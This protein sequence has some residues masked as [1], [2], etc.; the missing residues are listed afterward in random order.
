MRPYDVILKKRGKGTLTR[1]EILWFV[2]A[3]MSGKAEDYHATALAMA[4]FFNGMN[5][6]ETAAL[7]HAFLHS[8]DIVDPASIKGFAVDKHSTGGVGDT[9]SLILAP[10]AASL[11]VKVPMVSGRGLGHTGGTLDKLEAIPGFTTDLPLDEFIRVVNKIGVC[12]IGQ[13]ARM[14]PA[15]KRWYALRDVSAT[16]ESIPLIVASIMSKKLAEGISGLVLDVKVGSGAF[17]KTMEDAE[18]LAN[19]LVATGKSMGRKVRAVL[20]DMN[21]PLAKSVGNALETAEA[22]RI[23]NGSEPGPLKDLTVELS[24]HMLVLAGKYKTLKGAKSACLKNLSNGKAA[25]KFAEMIR[26]QKGLPDVVKNPDL[27]PKAKIVTA[28]PAPKTGFV[29][30]TDNMKLGLAS[31]ALGAGRA[32]IENIVDPAVGLVMN[33]RLGDKVT[34]G[35]PLLFIHANDP[36][37]LLEAKAILKSCFEIGA[38]ELLPP[39]LIIKVIE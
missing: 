12:M 4:I 34:K 19:A 35:R 5:D 28:F 36:K 37:R 2:K 14:C 3:H 15:D 16:V 23:L 22:I 39:P 11:G 27:L 13:T 32:G 10:L 8:G 30:A 29:Q 38:K 7:T 6:Q 18:T 24:A 1:R 25:A 21:Q 31:I 33:C 9:V 17:M 20:T 26:I